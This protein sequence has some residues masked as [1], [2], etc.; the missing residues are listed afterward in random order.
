MAKNKIKQHLFLNLN[1]DQQRFFKGKIS[2]E[3]YLKRVR[4]NSILMTLLIIVVDTIRLYLQSEG[5]A[6]TVEKIATSWLV[7]ACVG[8]VLFWRFSATAQAAIHA[9]SDPLMKS[10][11]EDIKR[12]NFGG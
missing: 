3:V 11:I 1:I 10:E 6:Q 7:L 2:A 9:K 4:K 5:W 12:E 8:A